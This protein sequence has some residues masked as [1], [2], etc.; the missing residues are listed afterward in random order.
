MRGSQSNFVVLLQE[1]KIL[2]VL[3]P[4]KE[5]SPGITKD[6]GWGLP[7][8]GMKEIDG[9]SEKRGAKR[10]VEE[11]TGFVIDE[12]QVQCLG[13][14]KNGT[15]TVWVVTAPIVAGTLRT[16][17]GTSQDDV[18]DARWFPLSAVF[19]KEIFVYRAHRQRIEMALAILEKKPEW[20]FGHKA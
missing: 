7:G 6:K 5:I 11:E 8:G 19:D 13:Y 2:L 3:N 10:E 18:L 1:G 17:F 16:T 9:G 15:H 20:R 4:A 12:E 14:D